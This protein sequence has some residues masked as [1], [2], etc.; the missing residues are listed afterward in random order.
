MNTDET[1]LAERK[2][3]FLIRASRQGWKVIA[4]GEWGIQLSREKT[5]K[6]YFLWYGA[7]LLIFGIGILVWVWGYIDYLIQ[8]DQILF[9]STE[10][11][12]SGNTMLNP[13]QFLD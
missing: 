8:R 3:A 4:E 1:S 13:D 6:P 2:S 5:Y 12:L 9:V 11:L 10:R 7:V